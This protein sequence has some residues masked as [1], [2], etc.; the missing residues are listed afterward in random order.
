MYNIVRNYRDKFPSR[1]IIAQNVSLEAAYLH[2]RDVESSS[3]T[4]IKSENVRR[5]E[6]VGPWFDGYEEEV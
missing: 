4:C 1:R 5:T 3:S 2:C 6:R